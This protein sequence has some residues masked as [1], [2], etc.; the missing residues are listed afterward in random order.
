MFEWHYLAPVLGTLML[1]GVGFVFG[2][3]VG[4]DR[5]HVSEPS[6]VLKPSQQKLELRLARQR[7]CI[8][9]MKTEL[10]EAELALIGARSYT[11]GILQHIRDQDPNLDIPPMRN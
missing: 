4:L 2:L 7:V 9:R 8:D 1:I 10:A 3:V 6:E 5:P 11:Q